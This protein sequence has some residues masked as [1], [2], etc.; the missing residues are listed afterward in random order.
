MVF[1]KRWQTV[2]GKNNR[3][4][5]YLKFEFEFKCRHMIGWGMNLWVLIG[6]YYA[7]Q[8]TWMNSCGET[9]AHI[10]TTRWPTG[11]SSY[12]IYP[13]LT[14]GKSTHSAIFSIEKLHAPQFSKVFSCW[15][16]RVAC[17]V[18]IGT[19]LQY[20]QVV[21]ALSILYWLKLIVP[22]PRTKSCVPEL[23]ID[24]TY[25]NVNW[26]AIVKIYTKDVL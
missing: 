17:I 21:L 9:F 4:I 24:C 22:G 15:H 12:K 5:K 3:Q 14:P 26:Q 16:A 18:F 20:L 25:L 10:K 6:C 1:R 23:I 7:A 13:C 11:W 8:R 19:Q 2:V